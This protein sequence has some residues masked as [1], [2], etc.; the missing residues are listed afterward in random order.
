MDIYK[1]QEN[2]RTNLLLRV[3]ERELPDGSKINTIIN[4][5]GKAENAQKFNWYQSRLSNHIYD[6]FYLLN[7]EQNIQ[8]FKNANLNVNLHFRKKLQNDEQV[9]DAISEINIL[10]L[11]A[12]HYELKLEVPVGTKNIDSLIEIDGQKLYLEVFNPSGF[13]PLRLFDGEVFTIPNRAKNKILDKCE[14]QLAQ[15]PE[16]DIPAIIAID[17]RGSD[18]DVG[19]ITDALQ[20]ST[21][22][23]FLMDKKTGEER[24][25]YSSLKDNSIHKTKPVSDVLSGVLCFESKMLNDMRLHIVGNLIL[26]PNAKNPLILHLTKRI[27]EVII[28]LEN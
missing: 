12:E 7:I 1:K 18:V 21:R 9:E 15:I 8:T 5:I 19:S 3:L 10:G 22:Y 28:Q 23:T 16:D 20:G 2:N 11:L 27:K 14:G 17:I 13:L 24:G 26:N 4:N 25:G 6:F